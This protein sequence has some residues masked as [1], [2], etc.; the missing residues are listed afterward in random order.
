MKTETYTVTAA[1]LEAHGILTKA[2]FY[3]ITTEF[4]RDITDAGNKII[5]LA[6]KITAQRLESGIQ[7]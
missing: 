4:N 2:G 6:A 5:E 7:K 1:D 3:A